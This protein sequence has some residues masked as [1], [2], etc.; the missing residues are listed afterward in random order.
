MNGDTL[1][2]NRQGAMKLA[3]LASAQIDWSGNSNK[4]VLA[5]DIV[6]PLARELVSHVVDE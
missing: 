6:D 5:D 2:P 4:P 3:E 1:H